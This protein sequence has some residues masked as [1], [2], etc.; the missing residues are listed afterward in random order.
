[1]EIKEYLN[2]AYIVKRKIDYLLQEHEYY[3]ELAGSVRGIRYDIERTNPNRNTEA[4]FIKF[5]EKADEIERKIED[6]RQELNIAILKIES[7][8]E[9]LD[10]HDEK[11]IVRYRH[12]LFLSWEDI[13]EKVHYS[14]RH[15][16]RKYEK[17]IKKLNMSCDVI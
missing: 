14:I 12:I 1:M 3:I 17:A 16:V 8:I 7:L 10:N 6:L 4:P 13:A 11:M 2:S 5:L 15:I 9:S